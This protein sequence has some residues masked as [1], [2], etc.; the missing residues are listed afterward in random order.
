M[1]LNVEVL[2]RSPT[3]FND[4]EKLR[5]S[6]WFT[7]ARYGSRQAAL[8]AAWSYFKDV[9]DLAK[10]EAPA[11]GKG[12]LRE[13]RDGMFYH[14]GRDHTFSCYNTFNSVIGDVDMQIVIWN[15][16]TETLDKP[17]DFCS[18]CTVERCLRPGVYKYRCHGHLHHNDLGL[19]EDSDE[20]PPGGLDGPGADPGAAAPE[21]EIEGASP[22]EDGSPD[23][24]GMYDE[25]LKS[26]L[27]YTSPS[28]RD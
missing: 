8:D 5:K 10:G 13:G 11:S 24:V 20:L 25:Y 21:E 7:E 18:C 2:W 12:P 26:S 23:L 3:K 22:G 14:G 6:M 16:S 4:Q 15:P 19:P 9:R 1:G 27:L 28:P 17:T